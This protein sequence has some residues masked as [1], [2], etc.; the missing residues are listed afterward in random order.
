MGVAVNFFGG[1]EVGRVELCVCVTRLRAKLSRAVCVCVCRVCVCG[2]C[3]VC[4][5]D[6]TEG[7]GGVCRAWVLCDRGEGECVFS[8]LGVFRDAA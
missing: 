1:W 7:G 8:V 2:R 5:C 3:G 4:V 6:S